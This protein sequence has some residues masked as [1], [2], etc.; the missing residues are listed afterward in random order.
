[1][2]VIDR[3]GRD[4]I[5]LGHNPDSTLAQDVRIMTSGNIPGTAQKI[6][7][8][9]L[10]FDHDADKRTGRAGWVD[11]QTIRRPADDRTA[12]IELGGGRVRGCLLYTSD[13]ADE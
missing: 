8:D 7:R 6:G 13:A 9:A 3:V 1:M 4:D 2:A 11:D 5:L 10:V 12:E